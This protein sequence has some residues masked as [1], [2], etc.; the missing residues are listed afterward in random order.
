MKNLEYLCHKSE[1][2]CG[3][4]KDDWGDDEPN[5]NFL[6]VPIDISSTYRPGARFGPDSLRMIMQSE[7][8]ECTS[9]KLVNLLD[10]Y[11]IKDWGNIGIINTDLDKSLRFVSEG[12]SDLIATK[13]P[14]F[15]IGGDHSLLIGIGDAYN[16]IE[17]PMHIVYLDAHLDLYNEVKESQF[18]HACTLRRLSEYENF[19]GATILGYRDFNRNQIDFAQEQG[20]TLHSTPDLQSKGDLYEF[21]KDL[22]KSLAKG[23]SHVHVSIDLDVLDPSFSPGVGNPVSCGL[24][25]RDVVNLVSGIFHFLPKD[26]FIGWD[27]VEYNPLFDYSDITAF[28]IIKILTEAL[29]EQISLL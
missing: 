24:S 16:Q 18:S 13:N 22:S 19:E 26:K 17:I 28:L 3:L 27:I 11:R 21:G 14:F 29:G 5:Y 4:L 1:S 2:Y 20:L 15:V 25:S 9:E 6:G 12:I 10:Y 7:N 8:Y 23:R